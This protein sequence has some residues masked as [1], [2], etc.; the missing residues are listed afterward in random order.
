MNFFLSYIGHTV[1]LH[2]FSTR[3]VVMEESNEYRFFFFNKKTLISPARGRFSHSR[4]ELGDIRLTLP[5]LLG[6]LH[7]D[8]WLR[9]ASCTISFSWDITGQGTGHS[10]GSLRPT[11][12]IV[13]SCET[14][15]SVYRP[16]PK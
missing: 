9:V 5:L 10:K 8:L 12:S 11:E 4:D 13:N 16:Y 7:V 2:G 14:E 15:P 3:Q 1:H 6:K